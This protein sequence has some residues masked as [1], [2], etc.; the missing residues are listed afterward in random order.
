M[1]VMSRPHQCLWMP[2]K[3]LRSCGPWRCGRR[4]GAASSSGSSA[5]YGIDVDEYG[6]PTN[7][8]SPDEGPETPPDLIDIGLR[9]HDAHHGLTNI[10]SR[11]GYVSRL[12]DVREV[13]MAA[14]LAVNIRGQDIIDDA[15]ALHEV[16]AEELG[17]EPLLFENILELLQEADFITVRES[18][19]T[20]RIEERIPRH[21]DLYERL[22][23]VWEAREPSELQQEL[24]SVM[25]GLAAA[26]RLLEDLR[27]ALPA[28]D[29][30]TILRVGDATGL[31]EDVQL[32]DGSKLLYSPYFAF[33]NPQRL[34]DILSRHPMEEVQRALAALRSHQ[35]LLLPETDRV[36]A[37]MAGR[38]LVM[39][40]TIDS[41]GGPATFGFLPYQ[42][43]SKLLRV[44]KA[45]LEKAVQILAC[46]RYGEHRA[47]ATR[48][49][50]PSAI[51]G[52][53]VDPSHNFELRAHSEHRRQYYT[54][55]RLQI[56]DFI[57][58]G[59]WVKVRLID[60]EDNV[61]AV[62]LAL[63]LLR[64]GEQ[65][66][67][68]GVSDAALDLLGHG[69]HYENTFKTIQNRKDDLRLPSE[70]WSQLSEA[71]RGGVAL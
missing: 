61:R 20:R 17:V 46:V 2:P 63:D 29:L 30:E 45:V 38:G 59:S 57:P 24:L 7:A 54:L 5:S 41:A 35:G 53:L 13:G 69:E 4:P 67:D 1:D 48:I 33:E 11:S 10:D 12:G 9:C 55:Y 43:E 25:H 51:L 16:A 56:V 42:V 32:E 15:E 3:G 14:N 21:E 70:A 44:E 64:Y 28:S 68:R 65:M 26:P 18:G 49:Q 39:A 34:G 52:R 27:K 60:T 40:P 66:K 23:E 62:R 36:L 50:S 47:V 6:P 37:D 58:S 71:M 8:R 19:S 31:I 22:G